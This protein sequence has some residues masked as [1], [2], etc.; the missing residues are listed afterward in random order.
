MTTWW[1]SLYFSVQF[2]GFVT[3]MIMFAFAVYKDNGWAIVGT[4]LAAMLSAW[5]FTD[6][7]LDLVKP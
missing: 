6:R 2:T 1:D 5:F 7:V 3:Q 4:L